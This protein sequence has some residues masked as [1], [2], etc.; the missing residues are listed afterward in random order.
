[1]RWVIA[2]TAL[3]GVLWA[4]TA[5]TAATFACESDL[6]C[7]G[8]GQCEQNG[9]CSFPDADCASGRRYASGPDRGCVDEDVDGAT[10]SGAAGTGS[11]GGSTTSPLSTG[12]GQTTGSSTS[13]P[14]SASEPMTTT[15]S[16]STSG[17]TDTSTTTTTGP[18]ATTSSDASSGGEEP[19]LLLWVPCDDGESPPTDQSEFALELDCGSCPTVEAG[20][21]MDNACGFGEEVGTDFPMIEVVD[22][23]AQQEVTLMMWVTG[24]SPP[25]GVCMPLLLKHIDETTLVSWELAVCNVMNGPAFVGVVCPED[26]MWLRQWREYR[27]H[28][29]GTRRDV[30]LGWPGSAVPRWGGARGLRCSARSLVQLRPGRHRRAGRSDRV[31]LAREFLGDR[32]RHPGSMTPR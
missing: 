30:G 20:P 15:T 23:F 21:N 1:M 28:G 6:Q 12:P 5:C 8:D 14:V 10:T 9:H 13:G 2:V 11:T 24:V 19:S 29:V 26:G 16:S 18:G 32:R 17:V 22:H 25:M 4:G 3:Q 27:R 7:G 31:P